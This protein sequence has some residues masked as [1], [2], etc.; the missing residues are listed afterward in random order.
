M[1][2][3][4]RMIYFLQLIESIFGSYNSLLFINSLSFVLKMTLFVFLIKQTAL[5]TKISR[6]WL[7][8]M[9]VLIG[10][11]ITDSAWIIKLL[12]LTFFPNFDYRLVLFWIRISWT[13]SVI[14]HQA[15]AIFIV[16]LINKEEKLK[17]HEKILLLLSNILIIFFLYMAFFNFQCFNISQKPVIE[18]TIQR[19]TSLYTFIILMPSGLAAALYEMHKQQLPSLLKKQF[20]LLINYLIIPHLLIEFLQLYP[21]QAFYPTYIANSYSIVGLSTMTFTLALYFC[22]RKIMGL[23]FLNFASHVQSS[24]KINFIDD[25]KETLTQLSHVSN[26]RELHHITQNFFKKVL[27]V[28]LG[29]VKLH[30]RPLKTEHIPDTTEE[31]PTSQLVETFL[32]TS[33]PGTLAIYLIQERICIYDEIDF[34][35]FYEKDAQRTQVL[36]LLEAINGDVFL[37]IYDKER[38]IGYIII[39]RHA[40]TTHQFYSSTDRDEMIV[41]ASYLGNIINLLQNK[42]FELLIAQEKRLKEE[43]YHKHQEINQYKESIRTFLRTSKQKQTGIIFYKNRHFTLANQAAKELVDVNI[44]QQE[45][46]PLTKSLKQIAIMVQ[47]YKS[48]QS[49]FAKDSNGNTLVIT[50][51]PHL[52]Q[53]TVILTVAPPCVSDIIKKHIDLLQD[54]SEWDYLLYLETTKSGQL[55]DQ[56]V[57]SSGEKLLNFKIDLLKL[58]LSKKAILL[59]VPTQDLFPITDLLHHISMRSRLHVLNIQGPSTNFDIAIKLFGINPIFSSPLNNEPCLLAALNNVGTLLITNIHWLDMETQ[60]YLAD[61]IK[62]GLYKIFKSDQKVESNV[63]IICSSDQNIYQ[64]TQDGLF[65]NALYDQLKYT[66][67]AMPSLFTLPDIELEELAL[68]FTQQAVKN[69]SFTNF[70]TLN[71]RDKNKINYKRPSSL[72]DLKNKVQQILADKSRPHEVYQETLF[73]PAYCVTDPELI[74]AARLGKQALKDSKL[75]VLLWNKFNK[76]QN[77]MATFLGVNRSSV[78]RRVKEY[79]LH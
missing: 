35:N 77:Q 34:S 64:L 72:H 44:N 31:S 36:K 7:L 8:L 12:S 14:Q 47:D 27:E 38:L 40:R 63:R 20:K 18:S 1:D 10:G 26:L 30:I 73:D 52:E 3:S 70:L 48:P 74:Q 78:S 62:Y 28:P 23:R 67:L 17:F 79:N 76:N 5:H 71:E 2:Y 19:I 60:E 59:D 46:H 16:N 54:P 9:L 41:F 22:A 61:F 21:I 55:I 4:N 58:S 15:L 68:G 32:S 45:G 25:F 43:L 39:E 56:L 42:S 37:P 50:A 66:T 11:A 65:S 29:K 75:M 13:F 6:S 51:V 24:V 57:P 49:C 33:E 69:S 53:N